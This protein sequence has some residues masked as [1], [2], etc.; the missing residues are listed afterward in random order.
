MLKRSTGLWVLGL[1]VGCGDA[2]IASKDAIEDNEPRGLNHAPEGLTVA[3]EPPNPS[4]AESLHARVTALDADGDELVYAYQWI[5]DGVE[6]PSETHRSLSADHTERGQAV[7]VRVTVSDGE[8]TVGPVDASVAVVNAQ[9]T[10]SVSLQTDSVRS[11]EELVCVAETD[12]VDSGDVLTTAYAWSR[13]GEAPHAEG[14]IY[15]PTI[16][17]PVGSSLTCT[18]TVS[19]ATDAV[20]ASAS[21]T[22]ENTP[23][24][25]RALLIQPDA[26]WAGAPLLCSM[27]YNRLEHLDVDDGALPV[28]T[29][30]WSGVRADGSAAP[31]VETSDISGTSLI[32]EGQVLAGDQ[33]TCTVTTIDAHGG[34][35]T[36]SSTVVITEAVLDG[37][38]ALRY[39]D[40]TSHAVGDFNG[41]GTDD[42]LIGYEDLATGSDYVSDRVI[43]RAQVYGMTG[44]MSPDLLHTLY[45]SPRCHVSASGSDDEHCEE[46]E[47]GHGYDNS[48][49]GSAV[50]APDLDGDGVSDLVIGART[51][52]FCEPGRRSMRGYAYVYLSGSGDSEEFMRAD[53]ADLRIAGEDYEGGFGDNAASVGDVNG[54][55]L[56]DVV[57]AAQG[58]NGDGGLV[59]GRAYLFLGGETMDVAHAA[60]A[61]LI[62]EGAYAESVSGLGRTLQPLGDYDGDGTDDFGIMDYW[63]GD[64]GAMVLMTD[65]PSSLSGAALV[66]SDEPER[67]V[68]SVDGERL[69]YR[70]NVAVGD[71][72]GDGQSHLVVMGEVPDTRPDEAVN[73]HMYTH[74]S[75]DPVE[76]LTVTT[77]GHTMLGMS[78]GDWDGDGADE[79]MFTAQKAADDDYFHK[80]YDFPGYETR[81]FTLVGGDWDRFDGTL[82]SMSLPLRW[83]G[84]HFDVVSTGDFSTGDEPGIWLHARMFFNAESR[85]I[86]GMP[87]FD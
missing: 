19:D 48:R 80:P 55:G 72:D 38:N 75:T 42:M 65:V 26:P 10:V 83:Q 53:D 16:E 45:P 2:T 14:S 5:V 1:V 46:E 36:N 20:S 50:A 57:I 67:L 4:T 71:F 87:D 7:S 30:R 68:S 64:S 81:L 59:E 29:L 58:W 62:V 13:D 69:V 61:D 82:S 3:I 15:T 60:D 63:A 35:S 9:P 49:F 78:A 54:D 28:P 66:F 12:D 85:F 77:E 25:T 56:D 79:L 52:G 11:G 27:E 34:R 70:T 86:Q 51:E 41:D 43:G 32:E 21:A 18:V 33:W 47:D 73:V 31:W 39:A 8:H 44:G 40:S 74:D 24:P 22:V 23:P 17:D 37:E 76:S 6:L 84:N